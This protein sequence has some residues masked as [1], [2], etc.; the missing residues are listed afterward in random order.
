MKNARLAI[1]EINREIL[2]NMGGNKVVPQMLSVS[3]W[4]GYDLDGRDDISWVDSFLIRLKEKRIALE[5]YIEACSGYEILE[6]ICEKLKNEHAATVNDIENFKGAI[7]NKSYFRKPVTI[8]QN[9]PRKLFQVKSW[10][11]K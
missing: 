7:K 11:K 8:L 10:R 6:D 9:G 1:R 3:T 4:V 5:I 2:L